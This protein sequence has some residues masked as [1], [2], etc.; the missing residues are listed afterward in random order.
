MSRKRKIVIWDTN[1]RRASEISRNFGLAMQ[2]TG[3]RHDLEIMS[4][5]PLVAR[6]GLSGRLPVLEVDGMLWNWKIGE[7]ISEEAAVKLLYLLEKNV[8]ADTGNKENGA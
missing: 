3:I 1:A 4:E 7:G 6:M 5:P 2:R 8:D